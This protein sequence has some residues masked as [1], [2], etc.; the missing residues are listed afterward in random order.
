[1]RPGDE[2]PKAYDASTRERRWYAWWREREF[3]RPEVNPEGDPYTIVIPPP[4]V[5]GA[6][7]IGHALNAVVQD[8]YVRRARMQ[9]RRA[10]WLYG[11][12]HAGIATQNVVEREL[13]KEGR[14]REGIG[15]EAF[16]AEVWKWKER[17]G[18]RI[19]EQLAGLGASC[20]WSRVRFTLDP[21]LSRAVRRVFVALYEK[22]LVYRG[23]YIVNWCPHC[24]TALSDEEVE[25]VESGGKL[26]RVAYPLEGGG[27]IE[28]ATTRP[29]T[30][31][32]DTGVAVNPGDERHR[33]LIGKHARLPLLD[34]RLPIVADDFVDPEFGTGLVKVT[35][36]HDPNDYWIG[37]RHGLQAVSILDGS[38]RTNEH[39]GP[40]AD[41]DRY[42]ARAR[43]LADL[44]AQ[45]LLR[46]V[47]DH[48][49]AL[50]RCYRCDTVVEPMLSDQW[51][52]KMAPLAAPALE[53]VREGRVR[54]HPERWVK[55]YE[56]WLEGIH[57]W[58][59]SRQL[60]WGHRI[61][62]WT[63][64]VCGEV[65]V[66]E[67]DPSA[68]PACGSAGLVQD[69]D[70][71]DTWFSS[72][73][74]PF[75]TLGWPEETEDFKTY[76]PTNLLVSGPDILFFWIARMIMFGIEFT[77]R[78]PF[79]DVHLT[80]I[81]RDAQGRK[82]SKSAG[83]TLD[84]MELVGAYGADALRF[85]LMFIA[86]PGTDLALG[87][88]K[89]E[90][91]RNFANKLWNASRYVLLNLG[92]DFVA[93]P[94]EDLDEGRF[95]LADRWILT[96]LAEVGRAVDAAMVDHRPNDVSNLLFDFLKHD[97]C[98][99][100]VEWSK[101]RLVDPEAGPQVRRLLVGVLEQALRLLHPLMPFLTEEIWQRLPLP[102]RA[103]ESISLA[104]W[105]AA[106][107]PE[108]EEALAGMRSLQALVG[109]IRELRQQ[110]KIPPAKK[111]RVIVASPVEEVRERLAENSEQ[112]VRLSGSGELEVHVSAR[113]PA[114]SA[115]AVLP[116]LEVFLPLEGLVDLDGER[117][118]LE[119]EHQRIEKLLQAAS[120]RLASEE[121][122]ERA[123]REVVLREEEK[124]SEFR[125]ILERLERNLEAIR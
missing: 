1:M 78:V 89:V 112:V 81:V 30:M 117:Q 11:I 114:A 19:A 43:V 32:G 97:Y 6:L 42:E 2:L 104:P 9:G 68:C 8:M 34:R 94:L 91:G 116:D 118:K 96:R 50:G 83:N 40:Y 59:I 29:E 14:T 82:M 105:E 84:P 101:V 72:A 98:D 125:T 33:H 123:P 80:G 49:L 95:D 86:A 69:E 85:T 120:R 23:K 73:L 31:L 93:G 56:N 61:P 124:R 77:G 3:F 5:T 4:N 41:L 57:D 75:S 63:C 115:S 109:A 15:R 46:G 26:Y 58:C 76:Y 108:S 55:V 39:A 119:R 62:V 106:K 53:A 60:W 88:D 52:V 25:H 28:V 12:D 107:L 54:L 21:G 66:A 71:L 102:S 67:T 51:F 17:H 90:V 74:W 110:L 87:R 45:G 103:A 35:P 99:W 22:D 100:Y 20:D 92:E 113:K 64:A 24:R 48:A 37:K 38:G 121:F 65:V 79:E 10:L 111:P 122:R 16:E 70:V 13:A 47:D 27:E 7:H 18:D 44:E 36:A